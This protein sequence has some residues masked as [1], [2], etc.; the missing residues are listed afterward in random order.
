MNGVVGRQPMDR[1]TANLPSVDLDRTAAFYAAMG[2]RV[3]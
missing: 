1:A 3:S 2:F